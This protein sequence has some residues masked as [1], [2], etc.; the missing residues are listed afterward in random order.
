MKPRILVEEYL[1]DEPV[2]MEARENGKISYQELQQQFGF[3]DYKFMCFNG[4]V[5][6]LFLDIGVIGGGEGHAEEYY[7]NVYDREGNL[8]P[9]L[10]TR[11]NYPQEVE[12]PDNLNEM[13]RIAETLSKGVPHVRVDLYR[14]STG[15]IKFGELTFFHGSGLSNRFIPE[16]WDNTFGS[17]INLGTVK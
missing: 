4:E 13:V 12:L 9:V 11:D 7:R 8:M 3:L 5:K 15:A 17:W 14:L 10:E 2:E 1:K 16:E 6:T